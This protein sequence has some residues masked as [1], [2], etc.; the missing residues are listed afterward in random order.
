MAFRT[1]VDWDTNH[2][3]GQMGRLCPLTAATGSGGSTNTSQHVPRFLFDLSDLV[4]CFAGTRTAAM[5][6]F[7]YNMMLVWNQV[8][9]TWLLG[10]YIY[11][12]IYI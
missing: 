5:V 9:L 12:N 2:H 3:G 8:L 11:I 1:H 4:G 6:A 7:S 10:I